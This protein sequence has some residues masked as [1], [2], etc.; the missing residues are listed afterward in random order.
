MFIRMMN[1]EEIIDRLKSN[2]ESFISFIA[3]LNETEFNYSKD[4]KWNAGQTLDHLYRAVSTLSRAMMLPKFLFALLFGK[5]N[6]DSKDYDG[7]V[8][9]YKGKL[10]DG[11]R[12]HGR[13]LPEKVSFANQQKTAMALRKS[14]DS[15]CRSLDSYSE[16]SL[17]RYILPHPLLGKV[18][19][20]EMLYFTIYHAEHHKLMAGRYLMKN[21]Q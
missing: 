14:V 4:G 18:T 9:K 21:D 16:T 20:R 5:A 19:I 3:A 8:A 12:A 7:L 17:D 1:K 11:G 13:Y 2:H 15:I 6:R 10:A